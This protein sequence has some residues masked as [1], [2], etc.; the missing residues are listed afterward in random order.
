[1]TSPQSFEQRLRQ[2]AE[3]IQEKRSRLLIELRSTSTELRTCENRREELISLARIAGASKTEI[4]EAAD[5]SLPTITR[6]LT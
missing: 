3:A 6:R 4:A 5:L 1:M 2:E